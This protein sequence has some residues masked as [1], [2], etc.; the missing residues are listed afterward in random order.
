MSVSVISP[1]EMVEYI[2]FLH[3][4]PI[5]KPRSCCLLSV[6]SVLQSS[7]WLAGVQRTVFGI[8]GSG[9]WLLALNLKY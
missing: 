2:L 6:G 5:V 1:V 7:L 3:F 9:L 4:Q 8:A